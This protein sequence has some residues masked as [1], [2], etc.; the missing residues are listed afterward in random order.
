P[1]NPFIAGPALGEPVYANLD[2]IPI[3]FDLLLLFR[4]SEAVPPFVEQAIMLGAK[5]IWMQQGI[6]HV[7][8][9]QQAQQAGLQVVMN[10]CM[11]V[12]HRRWSQ[13]Q[14]SQAAEAGR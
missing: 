4:R 13:N 10:A 8:A 6:V 3:P 1:V 7:D 12:E 14:K 2:E 11:M 9:A 5:A